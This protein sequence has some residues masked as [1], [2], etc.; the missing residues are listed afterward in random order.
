MC[1]SVS[2]IASHRHFV[3]TS[4]ITAKIKPLSFQEVNFHIYV[5]LTCPSHEGTQVADPSISAPDGGVG[6]TART[7]RFKTRETAVGIYRIGALVG[8]RRGLDSLHNIKT[9]CT[10][11]KP[12]QGFS[13]AQPAA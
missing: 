3:Q 1:L 2:L 4:P 11:H 5:K 12:N 10:Y 8:R 7:Y 6:S 9:F 13:V